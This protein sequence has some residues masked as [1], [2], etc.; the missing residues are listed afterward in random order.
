MVLEL[1]L[2]K[3]LVQ[4]KYNRS[5]S[6]G[7]CQTEPCASSNGFDN[8][9]EQQAH[10]VALQVPGLRPGSWRY[11][12]GDG[13]YFHRQ[14]VGSGRV[15][16]RC[17][18]YRSNPSC[19]ARAVM[20]EDFS[21]FTVTHAQHNHGP[22]ELQEQVQAFRSSLIQ[23]C[24]VR[25]SVRVDLIYHDVSRNV[26][27]DVSSRVSL[28]SIR[29]SMI[30]TQSE[31]RPNIPHSFEEFD[32]LLRNTRDLCT[33]LDGE[34][35]MYQGMTGGYGHR[36]LLF[37]SRRVV[38][39]AGEVRHLFG[40][41][42]YY[43]RPNQPDSMQLYTLVTVRDN[44]ILPL[45]YALM[46]SRS[47][48]AYRDL[49]TFIRRVVPKMDPDFFMSDFEMAQLNAILEI[50]P[51]VTLSGCLWHFA[52]AVCRNVRSLGL[53][54]LVRDRENARRVVRLCLGIP[55]AP[56]G[57]LFDAL[58]AVVIEARRLNLQEEFNDLFNYLRV[59]WLEGIGERT[60]CVFGVRHRTNNVAEAHHRNL[61]SRVVRRPNVWRFIEMLREMEDIAWRD[62]G[63][64]EIGLA[65][66]RARRVSSLLSDARIRSC[67]R[68]IMNREMDMLH[69]LST[70]SWHLDA[71][72]QDMLRD[73]EED[74]P[75]SPLRGAPRELPDN[76]RLSQE[77]GC[78]IN[79]LSVEEM[80][81]HDAPDQHDL[82]AADLFEDL[83]GERYNENG[84]PSSSRGRR[85]AGRRRGTRGRGGL[86]GRGRGATASSGRGSRSSRSLPAQPHQDNVFSE[87][88]R[89]NH[90][91]L[92]LRPDIVLSDTEEELS[93]DQ[94]HWECIICNN[95]RGRYAMIGCGAFPICGHCVNQWFNI[96]GYHKLPS[97]QWAQP[98]MGPFESHRQTW[99]INIDVYVSTL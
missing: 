17:V 48:I 19:P 99:F 57:R 59:T 2:W 78:A 7:A 16:L 31:N 54:E 90:P 22:D 51:R 3:N 72:M 25:P 86:A 34:C 10:P 12:V 41:A 49:F 29:P 55:L 38:T 44:H 36:S 94:R 58:N 97:L 37:L 26:P 32:N 84:R 45:A 39:G 85:G 8:E 14:R 53:H 98:R 79:D 71:S 56:P 89:P 70:V 11:H 6:Q 81:S 47:E 52:R 30:R 42:T 69:F 13:F 95:R 74:R 5:V 20:N 93:E 24:R 35:D 18:L 88:A 82:D 43:A 91:P 75:P 40:D 4:E 73:R 77:R 76:I 33:S 62:L 66:S 21:G 46:E 9:L 27:R 80:P 60:L 64:L 83:M 28:L 15:F 61:N 68:Q 23:A 92:N 96:L 63:R 67:S 50:I 1:F 65:P 87:S